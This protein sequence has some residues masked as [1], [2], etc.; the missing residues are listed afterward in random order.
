MTAGDPVG[1]GIVGNLARP[2]GNVT[3]VDTAGAD[4]TGKRV[5]VVC[6]PASLVRD[7]RR[8]GVRHHLV[9]VLKQAGVDVCR[10][11][12][13]EHGLWSTAQDLI[14]VDG[15]YTTTANWPFKPAY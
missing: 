8:P 7:P 1:T 11:F 4:L 13:P 10:L 3:G 2:E 9:D 5:G 6:N 15:G 14:A 12:G